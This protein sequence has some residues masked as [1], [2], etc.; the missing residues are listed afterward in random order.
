MMI[1]TRVDTSNVKYNVN[2][3]MGRVEESMTVAGVGAGGGLYRE[4]VKNG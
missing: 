2:Y 1:N 3:T 4:E